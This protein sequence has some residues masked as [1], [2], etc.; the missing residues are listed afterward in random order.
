MGRNVVS[1]N[2][3]SCLE[4]NTPLIFHKNKLRLFKDYYHNL[5]FTI[6]FII[7]KLGELDSG[8]HIKIK[9]CLMTQLALAKLLPIKEILTLIVRIES[10]PLRLSQLDISRANLD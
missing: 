4:T 10:T 3:I 9:I 1:R 2:V 6:F 8:G 5:Q 7:K